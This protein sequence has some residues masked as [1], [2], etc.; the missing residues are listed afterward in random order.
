MTLNLNF[1]SNMHDSLNFLYI[2]FI[3]QQ[4]QQQQQKLC[5]MNKK[6]SMHGFP[7]TKKKLIR[8]SKDIFYS[9]MGHPKCC[10]KFKE[11]LN[12]LHIIQYKY[13]L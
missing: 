12:F 7:K 11:N 8:W 1:G 3:I 2:I 6:E 4:Q 5:K 9:N 10:K 13:K